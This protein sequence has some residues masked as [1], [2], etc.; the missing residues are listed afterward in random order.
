[1]V[2]DEHKYETPANKRPETDTENTLPACKVILR[3]KGKRSET[4]ENQE[5]DQHG[6]HQDVTFYHGTCEAN[7]VGF[8]KGETTQQDQIDGVRAS[9]EVCCNHEAENTHH[10]NEKQPHVVEAPILDA[11]A[12]FHD[13]ADHQRGHD[14]HCE[15]SIHLSKEELSDRQFAGRNRHRVLEVIREMVTRSSGHLGLAVGGRGRW[16]LRV[17]H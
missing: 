11:C 3:L 13:V 6:L 8:T 16:Q 7:G 9:L 15:Q 17:R 1:M 12:Q 10:G 4:N 14:L 5:R 2:W